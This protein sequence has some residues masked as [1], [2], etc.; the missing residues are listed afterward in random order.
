MGIEKGAEP[1]LL[2]AGKRGV[3]LIHT[4]TGSPAEMKLLAD[5]LHENNFTVLSVRL[6][7]HGTRVEDLNCV[8]HQEWTS[9]VEDAYYILRELCYEVNV[10]GISLGGLLA[11]Q[12]AHKLPIAKVV[13]LSAPIFIKDKRV[14][15]LGLYRILNNYIRK[16]SRKFEAEYSIGYDKI[17][18][19]GLTQVL[20]LV[21]VVKKLLPEIT[22]PCLIGQSIREHTIKPESA[23]YIYSHLASDYKK[24]MWLEKSGHML[25]LDKEREY[26]AEQILD[27]L[28]ADV[29]ECT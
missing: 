8:R 26:V 23:N 2:S 14:P 29:S 22:T 27:F 15:F 21:K 19:R 25:V 4:F 28:E 3:L 5:Y 1:Y 7:G 18:L 10:V 17:P 24:L 20:K 6:P 13:S 9:A 16:K 11:L 12:L